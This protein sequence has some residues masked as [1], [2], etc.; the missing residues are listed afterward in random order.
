MAIHHAASGEIINLQIPEKS[1]PA[2]L[3]IALAKTECL[4]IIRMVLL[5]GKSIPEHQI[6]GEMTIQC[7][8]GSVE[9]YAHG[10]TQRLHSSQMVYLAR[11]EPHALRAV[12][13][14]VLLVTILFV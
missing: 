10:K 6:S 8:E 14:A 1:L 13:N 12:S 11:L 7:L 2:S 4:E 9:L 5:E 3:T